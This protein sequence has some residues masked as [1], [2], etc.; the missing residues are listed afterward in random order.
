MAQHFKL[1][2]QDIH[3]TLN[4]DGFN[5]KK[6]IQKHKGGVIS[7]WYLVHPGS[8]N[9][10]ILAYN[11]IC[12]VQLISI[13]PEDEE[14][15][16]VNENFANIDFSGEKIV[17]QFKPAKFTSRTEAESIVSILKKEIERQLA[18]AL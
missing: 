16:G 10:E 12:L 13:I 1:N 11:E 15:D 17:A 14:F 18:A 4:D 5:F 9:L 8:F 2:F 3:N 6:P 7:R